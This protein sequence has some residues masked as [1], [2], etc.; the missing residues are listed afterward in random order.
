MKKYIITLIVASLFMLMYGCSSD[1]VSLI[2]DIN[3]K[4]YSVQGKYKEIVFKYSS[5]FYQNML[6]NSPQDKVAVIKDLE[7][8]AK[9]SESGNLAINVRKVP[10]NVSEEQKEFINRIIVAMKEQI[11]GIFYA[12]GSIWGNMI[13]TVNC[14]VKVLKN[15]P[16]EI[17]L[18]E[19]F[20]K[21]N[22]TVKLY[23]DKDFV[24]IKDETFSRGNLMTII[25][26][27][28]EERKGLYYVTNIKKEQIIPNKRQSSLKIEYRE[29]KGVALPFVINYE[30]FL[31]GQNVKTKIT[32]EPVLLK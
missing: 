17:V 4:Y 2:N 11:E 24:I 6:N 12:T 16:Q 21:G 3:S 13:D 25:D 19:K 18:S 27:Q 28:I 23:L 10:Q 30:G 9:L 7:F 14:N 29:Y 22:L 26:R 5:S 32:L 20:K 1:N 15:T 8:F 31:Q